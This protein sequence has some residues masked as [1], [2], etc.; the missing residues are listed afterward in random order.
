MP[1]MSKRP[2]RSTKR[3]SY[4]GLADKIGEAAE[5]NTKL[6]E[7]SFRDKILE[8]S[9][10]NLYF[11]A[12]VVCGYTDFTH[13]HKELCDSFDG[14]GDWGPDWTRAGIY[15]FR[16]AMKSSAVRAWALREVLHRPNHAI[17]YFGS[18][19]DN[20]EQ[21]FL[22]P[23]QLL[24]TET[25]G[26]DF[27]RWLYR[28]R[29]PDDLKGWNTEEM[30]LKQTDAKA[31]IA[32]TIK[33]V[34]SKREGYHGNDLILD[35]PEG[36]EAEKSNVEQVDALEFVSSMNPLLINPSTGRIVLV[37]TVHGN[38]PLA[39]RILYENLD[40]HVGAPDGPIQWANRK[41]FWKIS[42]KPVIGGDGLPVWPE[43][44]STDTI[45]A[46]KKSTNARDFSKQYML[47]REGG[48]G[49]WWSRSILQ[50][51]MARWKIPNRLIAYRAL[52]PDL[53]LWKREG[54]FKADWVDREVKPDELFFF[55]HFDPKHKEKTTSYR[56]AKI[57][58]SKA[59]IVV[60]G[61]T[62]DFHM[63]VM[64]TWSEEA[65]FNA[66]VEKLRELHGKYGFRKLTHETVGAQAW[67]HDSL[68]REERANPY[69]GTVKVRGFLGV[70]RRVPR[71][72]SVLEEDKRKTSMGKEEYIFDRL[73]PY[74]SACQLHIMEGQVEL[75]EQLL[76][77]GEG[78]GYLDLADALAQGPPVWSPPAGTEQQ[79]KQRH[80]QKLLSQIGDK[81][82]KYRSPLRS[83]PGRGPEPAQ[84]PAL[85]GRKVIV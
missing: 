45:E 57:R 82:T 26:A 13:I 7:E 84:H 54:K 19:I 59:S 4:D 85:R 60:V 74:I 33:G 69:Y 12:K 2:S 36:A 65:G 61:V 44:F 52:Q 81:M 25:H 79:A 50:R 14:R 73:D 8:V 41:R 58:P 23:L 32:L 71:L 43:R 18:S 77:G 83:V 66:Q 17:R 62:P 70:E 20:A 35:D 27:R 28:H 31:P 49:G 68:D 16:G 46:I 63:I 47:L 1:S 53:D 37:G 5:G 51:N 64:E 22:R 78:N 39:Y 75:M 24:F 48:K 72:S 21:N 29:L 6:Y 34:T 40:P 30:P 55:G 15:W 10:R 67:L 42:W 56:R 38:D 76:S 80:E 3:N 9:E 11:F